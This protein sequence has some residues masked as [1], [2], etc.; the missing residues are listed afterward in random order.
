VLA[1]VVFA[2]GLL[3]SWWVGR[4]EEGRMR[5][6]LLRQA[7][8]I[9]DSVNDEWLERLTGTPQDETSPAYLRIKEQLSLICST[10]P[11]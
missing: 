2:A 11:L 10:N 7:Q 8:M 1:G 9:A 6:D 5:S 3:A 4:A